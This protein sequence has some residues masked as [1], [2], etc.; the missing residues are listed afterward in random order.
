[1]NGLRAFEATARHG[2]I[3]RA[4]AELNV[5][6]GAISRHIAIIEAHFGVPLFLRQHRGVQLTEAGIRYYREIGNA[7]ERI[8]RAGRELAPKPASTLTVRLYTTFLSDW[9]SSRLPAFRQIYPDIRLN[10]TGSLE[11]PDFDLEDIDIGMR[12]GQGIWPGLNAERLFTAKFTPI[13][14]PKLAGSIRS[15]REP[16]DVAGCTILTS[17]LHQ[18]FWDLWVATSGVQGLNAST[19]LRFENSSLVYQAAR[20][21]A[22]IG[23]GQLFYLIEDLLSGRL[24]APFEWYADQQFAYWLVCPAKRKDEKAIAAFRTW[25]VNEA[26]DADVEVQNLVEGGALCHPF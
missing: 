10:I 16:I 26:R 23:M 18:E 9:L 24:V 11:A 14:T 6:A 20:Q 19:W 2:N 1:L 25:L 21:G 15:L 5:T 13:C 8:E 12:H 4:A 3:A 17:P 22:G 7:F